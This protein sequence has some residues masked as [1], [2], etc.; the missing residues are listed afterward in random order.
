MNKRG[1]CFIGETNTLSREELRPISKQ[2]RSVEFS[3][4]RNLAEGG[5]EKQPD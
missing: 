5:W 4:E 2:E 3:S 1:T